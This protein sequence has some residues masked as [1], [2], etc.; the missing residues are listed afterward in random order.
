MKSEIDDIKRTVKRIESTV[1]KLF[2]LSPVGVKKQDVSTANEEVNGFNKYSDE[3][4]N[5]EDSDQQSLWS[6]ELSRK[7]KFKLPQKRRSPAYKHFTDIVLPDGTHKLQ[8][9][10]C[11][12][13]ITVIFQI[14]SFGKLLIS[15]QFR[16]M[17]RTLLV[18]LNA[19]TKNSL[20]SLKRNM[21]A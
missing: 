5:T 20:N 1:L 15:H 9:K 19:S 12:E 17:L 11:P 14:L 6:E 18:I 3:L 13:T 21:M 8:C 16:G 7:T 4:A 10:W 2:K